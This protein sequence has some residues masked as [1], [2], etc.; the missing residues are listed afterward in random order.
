M[1]SYI[2]ILTA[3]FFLLPFLQAQNATTPSAKVGWNFSAEGGAI[4]HGDH[5]GKTVGFRAGVSLLK[6]RL[7]INFF[8][9]GRSGPINAKNFRLELEE[10][11]RYKGQTAL[12]LRAD[13]AAYGLEVAPQ[14]PLGKSNITL[15]VPLAFGQLGAGFYLTGE[16]RNT[17]DGRR[18]SEWED[19]LMGDADA[20]FGYVL[21]GGLRARWA[22]PKANGIALG[23]GAYYTHTIGYF[24]FLG[25]NDFFKAPRLSFFVQFGN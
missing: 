11:V 23:L 19:E 7:A 4:L 6:R 17:P 20:G 3:L 14:F 21:E 22:L 18:V 10:G 15:D 24:S 2:S 12:N 5:L 8:Y 9:Y 13:H 16:D 1:K 25:G